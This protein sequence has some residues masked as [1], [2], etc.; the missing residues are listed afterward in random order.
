MPLPKISPAEPSK[1]EKSPDSKSD[2]KTVPPPDGMEVGVGA[3]T[4]GVVVG[5]FVVVDVLVAVGVL[6]A[7]GVVVG[8][9]VP[10][11]VGI[12]VGVFGDKAV[13]VLTEM[14][15]DVDVGG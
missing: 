11:D 8:T 6:V 9:G 4:V 10:V 2:R 14:V 3:A 13:C 1:V 7:T 15:V 5:V 12:A